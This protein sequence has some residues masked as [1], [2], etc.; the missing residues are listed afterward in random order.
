MA[1]QGAK[2]LQQVEENTIG[3]KDM[4]RAVEELKSGLA[5]VTGEVS[6]LPSLEAKI[7]AAQ[8]GLQ[9]YTETLAN[10]QATT[11]QAMMSEVLKVTT[12]IGEVAARVS[13]I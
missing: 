7:G 3:L 12:G 9:N 4:A 2:V 1:T 10:T 6:K 5:T 13:Q 11:T 8:T